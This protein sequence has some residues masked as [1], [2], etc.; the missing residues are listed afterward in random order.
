MVALPIIDSLGWRPEFLP[1]AVPG[2]L[3]E[4]LEL[5]NTNPFTFW[6]GHLVRY[7]LRMQPHTALALNKSMNAMRYQKPIVGCAE[8]IR[9]ICTFYIIL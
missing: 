8:Q 9:S 7:L 6:A 1:L 5:L 4:R 2:D 3:L